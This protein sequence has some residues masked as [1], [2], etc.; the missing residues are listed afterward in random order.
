MNFKLVAFDLDGV[1][2][3]EPSAWWTLHHAFGTYEA[4]KENLRAYEADVFDYPEFMRRDIRLW[5]TRGI[6]EV[7]SILHNFTLSEGASDVCDIL[8]LRGYQLAILS[9]GIDIVAKAVSGKVGIQYW[10]A[11][12]LEV[13]REGLLTG[14]GIFRV[15]LKKK[16]KALGELVKPLGVRLS[17][18]VGVGDSKY[19][20]SFMR[21]C[22]VGIAF[23]NDDEST[24]G[25]LWA[26]DWIKIHSLR[27]LPDTL[28]AI[29]KQRG[30]NLHS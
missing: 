17:N 25:R 3:E 19:D 2:V 14:E 23:V 10:I 29:G 20:V 27:D 9:A 7:K 8:R 16:E 26:K 15:D 13:D 12:G 18:V 6:V 21:A 28:L 11:N 24:Q 22:G 1:L 5:G 4:S 30:S